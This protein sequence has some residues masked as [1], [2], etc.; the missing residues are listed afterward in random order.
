L[1]NGS[2]PSAALWGAEFSAFCSESAYRPSAEKQKPP[3]H[4]A[5]AFIGILQ[6]FRHFQ[7]I[8]EFELKEN[9]RPFYWM[10]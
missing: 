8:C 10:L 1:E 4:R 5:A 2:A 3:R 6:H 7:T 9:W